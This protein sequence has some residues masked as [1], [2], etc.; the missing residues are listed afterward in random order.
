[1][2]QIY[3]VWIKNY[4]SSGGEM[5]TNETLMFSVPIEANSN[6][7]I[8]PVVKNEMGKTG[9]MEFSMYPNHPYYNCWNQL[10]TIMRVTLGGETLFRGRVLTIDDSPMTG[11]RKIHCEGDLAFLMD[12]MQDALKEENREE[13]TILTYMTNMINVHNSQ[14]SEE[15]DKLIYLGEVPGQYSA[16]IQD[17]QRVYIQDATKKYG[18]SSFQTTMQRMES[19]LKDYGGYFRT[20]YVGGRCYLDWLEYCY[21]IN[22]N[23]QEI[24]LGENLVDITS[25]SEV[26]NIFTALIPIGKKDGKDLTIKGYKTEVHGDNNRIL[27]P[28]IV[29][30]FP[31]SELNKGYHSKSDYL[32]AKNQYGVIFKTQNFSNADTQE[33][34]WSYAIDWIRE[35]YMGGINSFDISAMDLYHMGLSA[36]YFLAGDRVHVVYPDPTNIS[37][38]EIQK[39]LTILSAQYNLYN[40]EKNAYKVGIPNSQLNRTYGKASNKKGGSSSNS[41]SGGIGGYNNDEYQINL[42]RE[43]RWDEY[44]RYA[45]TYVIS[46]QY[47]NEEYKK[48]LQENQTAAEYVVRASEIAIMSGLAANDGDQEISNK[49]KL[50]N[51]LLNGT[52]RELSLNTPLIT[53]YEGWTDADFEAAN[54]LTKSIVFNGLTKEIG[55][56][57]ALEVAVDPPGTIQLD[58]QIL[59]RL[60]MKKDPND[61]P[62]PVLEMWNKMKDQYPALDIPPTYRAKGDVGEVDATKTVLGFDGSGDIGTIIMD[63][64]TSELGLNDPEALLTDPTKAIQTLKADGGNGSLSAWDKV[65]KALN[66]DAEATASLFGDSGLIASISSSLG[67]DG[68]G[69]AST[70]FQDGLTSMLKFFNPGTVIVD[71]THPTETIVLDGDNGKGN[72]GKKQDGTWKVKLNDTVTYVDQSGQTRTVDGFVSAGDFNIPE[73]ASFKTKF[74]VVDTLIADR[75]TINQLDAAVARIETL[76]TDALKTREL[77]SAIANLSSVQMHILSLDTGFTYQSRAVSRANKTVVTGVSVTRT[78]NHD[79]LYAENGSSLD[80]Y[81][82]SNGALVTGVSVSSDTLYYLYVAP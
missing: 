55:L 19:L 54:R 66:P 5:V 45:V 35:N 76:E 70:I 64:I 61:D 39:T 37:G 1:M 25:A 28:Q 41:A 27:V 31:D 59:L 48:L 24:R 13:I 42:E 10:K 71:P 38:G 17:S 8:N 43:S 36:D 80:P 50:R 34:L 33:K 47:N 15:P 11:E 26:D 78:N 29:G 53:T 23:Q 18:E 30:E 65:A 73:I 58:P 3:D 32:N 72:M 22:E 40:P 7:L 14:M 44:R 46:E 81:N 77:S 63:G 20:R 16:Y 57:N 74:A 21:R 51:I 49:K 69:K 6:A 56:K 2:A 62:Q 4:R 67:F 75:A 9:S 68:S 52:K 12:S 82:S 60:K 79:F